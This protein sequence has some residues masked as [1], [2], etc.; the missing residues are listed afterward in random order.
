L[1]IKEKKDGEEGNNCFLRTT[2]EFAH[3]YTGDRFINLDKYQR[4]LVP[5]FFSQE[6]R[7]TMWCRFCSCWDN[8]KE[9]VLVMDNE[10]NVYF[11]THVYDENRDN[12]KK[13]HVYDTTKY[14]AVEV[15]LVNKKEMLLKIDRLEKDVAQLNELARELMSTTSNLA[16]RAQ[17]LID[18]RNRNQLITRMLGVTSFVVVIAALYYACNSLATFN[19]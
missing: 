2:Q 3:Y 4:T 11:I 7:D 19:H 14:R 10:N 6:Q 16:Q 9:A 12:S 1:V 8:Q 15:P 13:V 18:R 17:T 5:I